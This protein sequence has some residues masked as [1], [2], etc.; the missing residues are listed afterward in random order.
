MQF[1]G[2]YSF[3]DARKKLGPFYVCSGCFV[4]GSRWFGSFRRFF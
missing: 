4:G 3:D 2:D 1:G